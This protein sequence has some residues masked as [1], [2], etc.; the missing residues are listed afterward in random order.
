M[1]I[2]AL[3]KDCEL[4]KLNFLLTN[5]V[6]QSA[7]NEAKHSTMRCKHGAVIVSKTGEIIATGHNYMLPSMRC[8]EWSEHAEREAIKNALKKINY[9]NLPIDL[10][11]VRI[12]KDN[13]GYFLNSKPCKKCTEYINKYIKNGFLRYVFYSLNDT[14]FHL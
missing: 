3:K 10:V 6:I 5:T 8:G 12:R 11:V 9:R 2:P 4:S 14:T 7:I 1:D 13:S